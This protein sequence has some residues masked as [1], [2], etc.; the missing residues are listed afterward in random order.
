VQ[1]EV[2]LVY[3]SLKSHAPDGA[4]QRIAPLRILSFDIECM[5]RKGCFPDADVD[6]VI[7]IASVCTVQGASTSIVRNV[8]TFGTCSP[9]VGATVVACGSEEEMLRAWARFLREVDPDILTGYNVQNFDLPYILNRC[10]KLKVEEAQVLGRLAGVKASMRDTTF[11]SSAHGKRENIETQV[12]GRVVFDMLQYMRR[13]HKLSSYSLNSVSAHFLGQQKED[14]HHSIIADLQRGSADDR[15]RLAVYCLKDAF[16]PQRLADKLMV[17]INHVEL[18]RVVGV[19]LDFLLSRGQQIRVV[20]MLYR[21]CRPL[22]LLVPTLPRAQGAGDE[23][24][25]FEGATVLEPMKGYYDE[26]VS[27]CPRARAPVRC[28]LPPAPQR[29]LALAALTP[30][31]RPPPPPFSDR[32]PLWTLPPCT[33][34]SCRRTTCATPRC[35]LPRT[36]R[37]W[38]PRTASAR[39]RRTTTLCAPPSAR[40]CC[41]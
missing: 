40:A 36:S 29:A 38:R 3:D 14:V 18:C 9:I 10:K 35:W 5:G 2:D 20:S 12:D 13:E 1:V 17:V 7:Q 6:P 19:P 30:S 39:P 22:G 34:P 26:P 16:L 23:G 4:W 11:Q 31:P 24:V 32:L 28:A 33:P 8:F 37:S 41:P 25:A 21:K 15:R 27:S